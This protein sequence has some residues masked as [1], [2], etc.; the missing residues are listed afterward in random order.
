[1]LTEFLGL[2]EGMGLD[3][4]VHPSLTVRVLRNVVAPLQGMHS[5]ATSRAAAPLVPINFGARAE[6]LLAPKN[7]SGEERLVL[8]R[9]Y[10]HADRPS[11]FATAANFALGWTSMES[12]AIWREIRLP[13]GA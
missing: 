5:L 12:M 7:L 4:V 9:A 1:M 2:V 3:D 13:E 6:V 10:I 8:L 11:V